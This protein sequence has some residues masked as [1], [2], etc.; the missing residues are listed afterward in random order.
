MTQVTAAR[1]L[2]DVATP[3]IADARLLPDPDFAESWAAIVLPEGMKGEMARSVIAS[4]R[5]RGAVPFDELPLHGVVL[6]SGPPGVGK[7]TVARGL[8]DKVAR[9][10]TG[11]PWAFVEVDPHGL[12]S[13]ALGRSQ[14]A[15]EQLM[16][17]Q[18]DELAHAGPLVVLIDEVETLFT[19]RSALSMETNPIDVHRAVDAGLVGL[20]RLARR[21]ANVL[22]IA[23]TN[24]ADAIDP[25]LYSRADR[26]FEVPLPD[27]GAR[28]EILERTIA[29]VAAAFPGAATL[30]DPKVLDAAAEAA[31]GLDGRQLRKAV[32]A[33]CSVRAGAQGDP[34]RV[35]PEDLLT[36]LKTRGERA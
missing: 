34:D 22:I 30:L 5:L 29:A 12:A 33:A 23:T 32:A 18:L 1:R 10:L 26:V 25:A 19:N 14:R 9:M 24:F 16:G 6:L 17:T 20:D 3:G 15:V 31:A 7:T 21:H 11:V 8:A 27:T 36:V 2:P 4:T 13:S 35:T 28:R